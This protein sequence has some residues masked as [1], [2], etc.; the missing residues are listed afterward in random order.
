MSRATL[1]VGALALTT[2]IGCGSARVPVADPTVQ[3]RVERGLASY[4]ADR[5]HGR[6]TASGEVYSMHAMTAAHRTLPFDT[7][8]RVTHLES[9]KSIEV[10]IN[11]RG[12]FVEGRIIDLS[13]R[14]AARL[15][16]ID[17]GVASVAVEVLGRA[18]P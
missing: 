8:V 11:D 10:R 3:G 4:Y 5:Y 18:A 13:R 2:L 9:G 16:M 6:R 17:A 14:A 12:P 7:E 1:I 15:G